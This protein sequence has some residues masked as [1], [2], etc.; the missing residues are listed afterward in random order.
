MTERHSSETDASFL[1]YGAYDSEDAELSGDEQS[2]EDTWDSR[3]APEKAPSWS[4][5]HP[6][7]GT[8]AR[9]L[10]QDDG[11]SPK[12]S[13]RETKTARRHTNRGEQPR[14]RGHNDSRHAFTHNSVSSTE[15]DTE[16][17]TTSWERDEGRPVVCTAVVAD[18]SSVMF[19][20]LLSSILGQK[21][22]VK[23][24]EKA[25]AP[26]STYEMVETVGNCLLQHR[27]C[28]PMYP[29]QP[30]VHNSNS[31]KQNLSQI[32]GMLHN[33]IRNMKSDKMDALANAAWQLTQSE[34]EA[35][36]AAEQTYIRQPSWRTYA[37]VK[38][39]EVAAEAAASYCREAIDAVNQ[40]CASRLKRLNSQQTTSAANTDREVKQLAGELMEIAQPFSNALVQCISA[41]EK[42]QPD[43]EPL[44]NIR[45]L[46]ELIQDKAT[47]L[48]EETTATSMD[49][50]AVLNKAMALAGQQVQEECDKIGSLENSTDDPASLQDVQGRL[51]QQL[52]VLQQT[53]TERNASVKQ[54]QARY[55]AAPT[56]TEKDAIQL[57]QLKQME[58]AS[59][60]KTAVQDLVQQLDSVS[61][62]LQKAKSYEVLVHANKVC[63][64][65]NAFSGALKT[66]WGRASALHVRMVKERDE[67]EFYRGVC[68]EKQKRS[69]RFQF[70][71]FQ[72]HHTASVSQLVRDVQQALGKD[73]AWLDTSR[74]QQGLNAINAI[75]SVV[76]KQDR[77]DKTRDMYDRLHVL[78]EDYFAANARVLDAQRALL[79]TNVF[80]DIQ[81]AENASQA[82]LLSAS[83]T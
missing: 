45:A 27:D 15:L 26:A 6:A 23:P 58:E 36:L 38:K 79:L 61:S 50:L 59:A 17:G 16:P 54:L 22:E 68:E 66:L 35:R 78:W 29:V 83:S 76:L 30:A 20:H 7:S 53:M 10:H 40:G 19:P 69:I 31:A 43:A 80:H 1:L 71:K 28:T 33:L 52:A 5:L 51:K 75:A 64:T 47:K 2:A 57:V 81:H 14:D 70:E 60:T 72:E 65:V 3:P 21:P 12:D 55:E 39:Y 37:I 74:R 13:P 62:R 67:I 4:V 41:L 73:G 32:T 49:S 63:A 48:R 9:V 34:E 8:P 77:V 44:K 25:A 82:V 42:A 56:I 11:P 46:L 24:V 18:A